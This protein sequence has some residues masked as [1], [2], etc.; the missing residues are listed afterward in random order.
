MSS[1][2]VIVGGGVI[3]SSIAYFLRASDPTVSVTVIERDPSYAR[4]S[5]AL[6]AASIRQQFSTP[7]SIQ[8]SLYGIEFL[9]NIGELLE[10]DGNRPSIDLHEGG[11]LFLATPAGD[12]TLRENHALQTSL[13]ADIN[14]MDRQTL[15]ARFSW[16]NVEDLVSG[17]FGESGEGW[18]DGYGLVQALRK[19]AQSLGARYVAAD[20]TGVVREGRKITHVIAGNGERYPCDTVVNAA[21][22]WA[23]KIAGMMDIDIPVFARRRSIFNVSSPARLQ[24]CPLLIDPTGVYFRP[25]GKTYI[26]GTSPGADNDPDD[27][28][29]DEVDHALFDD[30]IWPTLAHRVPEFEA[31]RVENCWSG[32]YEYNVFDHNAII[33]YHPQIEN[34]VF[35]NGYSGH[36]LQQGPATGRGVSE[37]I[38]NGRY[39]SLDLSSLSWQRLLENR[40]IVEKNVV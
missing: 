2:V 29:L 10:V 36:G 40:P 21:G 37:L 16:L 4:S 34:C 35:A 3:G 32:Y 15:K 27:L 28:P 17:A 5:S 19:K 38:L 6:S 18:F 26:C 14:L 1:Q 31:L 23:R 12:A 25:E 8:M 13:G 33:G 24:A 9:R 30:V 20:V 22:A 7:L 39:V 11:Y